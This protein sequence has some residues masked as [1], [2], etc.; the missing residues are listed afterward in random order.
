MLFFQ[1]PMFA[2]TVTYCAFWAE[3]KVKKWYHSCYTS[4]YI[5]CR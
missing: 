1:L 2:I 4:A 5:I 3:E